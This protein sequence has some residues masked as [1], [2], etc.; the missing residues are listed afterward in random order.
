MA[1]LT[2]KETAQQKLKELVSRHDGADS[3]IH[4]ANEAKTR[5]LIIDEVLKIL[6][7]DSSEFN[8]EAHTS[9]NGY[10]DYLLK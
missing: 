4:L 10:I 3:S 1:N 7:W 2:Q 9:T 6:G 8:P 5:L